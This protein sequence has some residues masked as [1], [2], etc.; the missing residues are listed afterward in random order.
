MKR[1]KIGPRLLSLTTN[2]KCYA[3]FRLCQNQR[4]WMTLK[5]IIVSSMWSQYPL[6]FTY[7][8][9]FVMT[10]VYE[11]RWL[12]TIAKNYCAVV[13]FMAVQPTAVG[14]EVCVGTVDV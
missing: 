11:G 7:L 9:Y 12:R 13:Y 2:R 5:V 3:R 4:P 1:S 14:F 6:K 10:F 8:L